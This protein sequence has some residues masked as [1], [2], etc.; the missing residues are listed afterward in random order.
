MRQSMMRNRA[1]TPVKAFLTPDVLFQAASGLVF[2][3]YG[4][5]IFFPKAKFTKT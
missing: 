2:P 1:P 4:S 3:A 5:M